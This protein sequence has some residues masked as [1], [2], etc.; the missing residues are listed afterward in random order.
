MTGGI[1]DSQTEQDLKALESFLVGNED[2][3]R[4][5]ALLDRF[6][7][8]E[9]IGM[10]NQE[11]SHS[12]FL[13]YLLNPGKNHGLGDLFVKRFL[14]KILSTA[15][16][17]GERALAP[18]SA[19]ELELWDLSRLTVEREWHHVDILLRDS[20]HELMVVI[21]NKIRAGERSGQLQR[22]MRVVE[23]HYPDWR[24]VPVFLTPDGTLPSDEAYLAVDYGV[25][26]EVIDGVAESRAAVVNPDVKTLMFHYTEMLRRQIVEDSR[27]A[28]LCRQIYQK[29]K[30]ALDLIYE[31]RPDVQ[32][33]IRNLLEVLIEGGPS[34]HG[35]AEV[36]S[37]SGS[38][39][40]T[41]IHLL[42]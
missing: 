24:V 40:G 26:C 21:E 41:G 39:S 2:L 25:V 13:A 38:L 11:L 27:V 30:R 33:E 18:I 23:E 12:R 4:L 17:G 36:R 6:N 16:S 29:H 19:I 22:Y 1:E 28:E 31:H 37:S 10:V 20:E 42:C 35:I 14:Q 32:A 7:I 15:D 5:E 9:V 3:D 34:L 8:F